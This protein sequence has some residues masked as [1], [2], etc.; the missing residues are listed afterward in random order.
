MLAI[1]LPVCGLCN[2]IFT[3]LNVERENSSL[4]LI[5]Q[6]LHF[7]MSS[8]EKIGKLEEILLCVWCTCRLLVHV[9]VLYVTLFPEHTLCK[10][11][12]CEIMLAPTLTKNA[13]TCLVI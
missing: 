4:Y 13:I 8:N 6:E 5:R 11:R 3:D 9:E 12:V 2:I 1:A 10:Y 7:K